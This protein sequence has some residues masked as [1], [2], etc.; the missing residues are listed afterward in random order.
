MAN[1]GSGYGRRWKKWVAIYAVVG[2]VVYLTFRCHGPAT[3]VILA[4]R[5]TNVVRCDDDGSWRHA[6]SLLGL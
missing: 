1:N 5:T 2:V 6:T 4:G 3:A